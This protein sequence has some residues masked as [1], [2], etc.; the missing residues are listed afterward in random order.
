MNH[1]TL[2]SP[3]RRADRVLVG[4]LVLLALLAMAGY[5]IA[6]GGHRGQMVEID[7]AEP[8]S[9]TFSVDV[10]TATWP[11]LAQLPG[12]GEA[13]AR[14]IVRS[15][16]RDGPF[17]TRADIERVRGVGP[18]LLARIRPYLLPIDTRGMSNGQ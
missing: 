15:R 4:G 17:R 18:V 1:S 2:S 8:L 12:I 10:N 7:R 11:E 13:L 5:W 3:L 9:A 14:R 16:M 6:R